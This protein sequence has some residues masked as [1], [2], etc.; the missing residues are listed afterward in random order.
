MLV[1]SQRYRDQ[2][3]NREDCFEKLADVVRAALRVPRPRK[4]T[5]PSKGAKRRRLA[6]KKMQSAKK[7]SRKAGGAEE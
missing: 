6:D 1:V 2:E 5:K 7:Q 4:A 3:R